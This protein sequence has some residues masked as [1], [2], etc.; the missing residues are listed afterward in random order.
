[1]VEN[2]G[3]IPHWENSVNGKLY[4]ITNRLNGKRYFGQTIE[5]RPEVRWN[6]HRHIA[7]SGKRGCAR[8]YNSMRK[9]G[10]ENFEFTVIIDKIHSQ[11]ELN[12]LEK[13]WIEACNT[14]DSDFGYNLKE[15]GANGKLSVD[16]KAKISFRLKGNKNSSGTVRTEE[17]IKNLSMRNSGRKPAGFAEKCR[18]RQLGKS[19]SA[20][21]NRKRS[22]FMKANPN[23]GQIKK[24]VHLSPETCRKMS[25]SRMG[26]I[27]WNKGLK[28]KSV[29][30][31]HS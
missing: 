6:N 27:P 18:A 5:D 4:T 29:E 22:E 7:L 24:G 10:V 30:V 11:E 26:R 14:M 15:G 3:G 8:L 12:R 16:T 13:V 28:K 19:Q 25:A 21:A 2:V 17:Y 1:M 31:C 20:E 9:H 23:S